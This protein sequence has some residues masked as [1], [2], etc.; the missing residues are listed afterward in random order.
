MH[1]DLSAVGYGQVYAYTGGKAFDASKPCVVFIHGAQNDHSVW[2]LQ[3]RYLA[4]HGYSVLAV[5]L[6]GHG[7]SAGP[8]LTTVPTMAAWVLA[9]LKA[10]AP[11]K[12]VLAGHSMGSLIAIEAAAQA[13]S[14][15][16]KPRI[17][18]VA[19]V[20]CAYPMKVSDM[21][22][23]ATR[24]DEP[25]AISMINSWSFSRL[26]QAPGLP[27][28]GFSVFNQSRRLMERQAPGVLAIDFAACNAYAGGELAAKALNIPVAFMSAAQDVMTP[29]KAA[30]AFSG[31]FANAQFHTIAGCG[32]QLMAERPEH[33]L[34]LLKQFLASVFSQPVAAS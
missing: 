27:G 28:P 10:V 12:V 19:A 23:Q 8:A 7:R 31:Q 33:T 25:G 30:R 6:P 5:D 2:I 13:Q 17:A 15:E 24:E 9:L 20:A 18:G 1:I 14:D 16:L 11:N 26:N 22:L 21:L 29:A 32:H 3:S 4:H 34:Q